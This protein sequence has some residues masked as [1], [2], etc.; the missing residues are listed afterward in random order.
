M[1]PETHIQDPSGARLTGNTPA[2]S[3]QPHPPP[4]EF[5]IICPLKKCGNSRRESPSLGV[6][7]FCCFG[8]LSPTGG[9]G[10][11]TS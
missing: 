8:L 9:G 1:G 5:L 7:V 6:R 10:G 11:T 4:R 3:T 2:Q